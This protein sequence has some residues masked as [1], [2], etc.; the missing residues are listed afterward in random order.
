V[1]RNMDGKLVV[2]GNLPKMARNIDEK[3]E[4]SLSS[5]NFQALGQQIGAGQSSRAQQSPVSE[6]PAPTSTGTAPQK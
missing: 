2:V 4:K 6:T 3:V 5:A 1:I